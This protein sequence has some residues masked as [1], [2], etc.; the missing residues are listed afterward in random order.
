MSIKP[1]LGELESLRMEIKRNNKRN[2]E[3]RKRINQIEMHITSYLKNKEQSGV[4]YNGQAIVVED[5]EVK[6]VKKK[7]D[8]ENDI[9]LVLSNLGIQNTRQA[10]DALE[11]ARRND[12]Q[13]STK[14]KIKKIN[15]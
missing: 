1:Y 7:A 11:A 4:K 13:I 15:K 8:L 9:M 10:F 5:K 3:L 6:K 12:A 14:L 2:G